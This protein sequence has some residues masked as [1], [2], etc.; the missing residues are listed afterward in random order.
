M[1]E[2]PRPRLVPELAVSDL[3]ASLRFW[4][5]IAGFSI[6]YQRPEEGFAM[7]ERDGARVMLE[8]PDRA[9]RTWETGPLEQPFGRG[10][11]F[12]ID[13]DD[14]DAILARFSA[15]GAPLF[16]AAEE[17]WYRH[18]AREIGIRQFLA[19]DPDGYLLRFSQRISRRAA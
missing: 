8:Q 13:V 3:M 15:A 18:G 16:M 11:N 14:L 4:I 10:V 7:L 5:E 17:K 9:A 1:S 19:Q 2:A 12:E 6:A